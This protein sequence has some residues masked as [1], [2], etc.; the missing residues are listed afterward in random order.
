MR[1]PNCFSLIHALPLGLGLFALA[2]APAL[3]AQEEGV[4]SAGPPS[5]RLSEAD[6]LL[7]KKQWAEAVP[8]LH[9]LMKELPGFLPAVFEL[10][11]AQTELGRRA[12]AL[13][14]LKEA[15]ARERGRHRAEIERRIARISKVFLKSETL[16]LHEDG[17]QLLRARK[18]SEAQQRFQRAST[19]E[20]DH[21]E[22]LLR[23]GQ[24][25]VLLEQLSL[26]DEKLSRALELN[27]FESETKLWLGR[28]RVLSQKKAAGIQLLEEAAA[29]LPRSE[30]TRIWLAE[31]YLESK[32]RD[33]AR[34]TLE[35]HVQA[36]PLHVAALLALAR[37][38]SG[39]AKKSSLQESTRLLQLALSRVDQYRN[40]ESESGL[41]LFGPEELKGRVQ[42]LVSET[43]LK[44]QALSS[45]AA[46]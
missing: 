17:V 7:R 31:A 30:L 42:A 24:V 41:A 26:A 3:G 9:R 16:Q 37:L 2:G 15:H 4:A 27:P 5:A 43:D 12:D 32:Q 35:R 18:W 28:A 46:P 11:R 8:V 1:I 25:F 23:E 29:I 34:S 20:P 22:L 13:T 21:P 19:L 45:T 6:A 44:L 36:Y 33:L 14:L 10:A 38:H 39:D 40:P